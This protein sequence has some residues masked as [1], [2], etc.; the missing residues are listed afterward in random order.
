M[1]RLTL[2]YPPVMNTYYRMVVVKGTPRML[3]SAA[4]RAY[5]TECGW[6]AKSQGARPV[7]GEIAVTATYYRPR[8]RGD[9][10]GVQKALFD[11]LNGVAWIDDEQI[12]DFHAKRREDKRN[13]RVEIEIRE[14]GGEERG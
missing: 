2:P 1:I 10:D 9:I 13:P 8:R 6:M 3:I 4:G 12:V 5:K 7:R 14:C 11:A